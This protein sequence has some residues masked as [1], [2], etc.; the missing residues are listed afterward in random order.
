MSEEALLQALG[1]LTRA[2]HNLRRRLFGKAGILQL[3]FHLGELLFCGFLLLEQAG[4]FGGFVHQL[5][6]GDVEPG[7]VGDDG[8]GLGQIEAVSDGDVARVGQAFEEGLTVAEGLRQGGGDVDV[9]LLGRGTFISARRLRTARMASITRFI[10]AS[11]SG[12]ER[13]AS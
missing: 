11:A 6:H 1:V 13:A 3:A 4:R 2:F 10:S 8:H 9:R 7:V 5:I 12:K